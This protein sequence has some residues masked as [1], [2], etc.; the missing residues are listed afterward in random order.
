MG[1]FDI[2]VAAVL[3]L[4]AFR[5]YRRGM[6]RE[7][8]SVLTVIGAAWIAVEAAPGFA[9]NFGSLFGAR[10]SKV[11]DLAALAVVYLI[12]YMGL[13]IFLAI[14]RRLW[15]SVG[16]SAPSRVAGTLVGGLKGAVL[17]GLV[18]ALLQGTPP[19]EGTLG[20][21]PAPAAAPVEAI[22]KRVGDSVLAPPLAGLTGQVVSALIA[23]GRSTQSQ[24]RTYTS[25]AS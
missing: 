2:G 10:I 19:F 22:G 24:A 11:L 1:G 6:G 15:I 14:A 13:R 18:V 3:A 20:S 5:G 4:F 8:L 21:L 17:A 23:V 7:I 16:T 12:A 9:D 25:G